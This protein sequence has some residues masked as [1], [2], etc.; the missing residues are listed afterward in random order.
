MGIYEINCKE[1]GVLVDYLCTYDLHIER[2]EETEENAE[3]V[4]KAKNYVNC[5]QCHSSYCNNC[6]HT[7]SANLIVFICETCVNEEY[8]TKA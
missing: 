7:N 5:S 1:C 6:A 8:V 3:V 2:K 4:A